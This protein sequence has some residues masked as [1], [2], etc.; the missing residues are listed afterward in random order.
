[1]IDFTGQN[2]HSPCFFSEFKR[3]KMKNI[4][5]FGNFFSQSGFIRKPDIPLKNE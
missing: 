3:V 2:H 1:M 5:F 4:P